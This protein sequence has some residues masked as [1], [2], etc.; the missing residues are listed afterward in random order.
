MTTVR[1]LIRE[2]ADAELREK[3]VTAWYVD[4]I[5]GDMAMALLVTCDLIETPGAEKILTAELEASEP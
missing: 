3:T 4:K 2:I 5:T 1:Q